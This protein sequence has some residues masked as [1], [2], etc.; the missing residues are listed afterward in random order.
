MH[1]ANYNDHDERLINTTTLAGPWFELDNQ[2]T[3][4]QFKALVLKGSE[5][6]FIK[7]YDR[8]RNG[9]GAVL[10]L[11]GQCEGTLAIQCKASAYA[12]IALVHYSGQ[13]R[14]FTFDNYVKAHQEAHNTLANLNEPVPET[15]QV[16]DFLAGITDSRLANAKDL[17]LGEVQKLQ[18]FKL[19]QQYL[20]MLVY[21]KTTQEK[22]LV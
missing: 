11:H 19:C 13:K 7:A 3:Y 18:N 4:E 2:Q 22:R 21:N 16:M 9:R 5:C 8:T 15:K 6:S 12:K 17:I 10:A 14:T 1:I 20:K